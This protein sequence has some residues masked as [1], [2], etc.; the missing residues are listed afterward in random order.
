MHRATLARLAV[1]V[2]ALVL[3][4]FLVR[5]LGQFVVGRRTATLVAGPIAV[6]AA[7]VLV[8]VVA[9][10]TLARLGVVTIDGGDR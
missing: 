2:F 10:W 6:L 3:A 5:G 9:A 7:V 1:L 8:V 4:S